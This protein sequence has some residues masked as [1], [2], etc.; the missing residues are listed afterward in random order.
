MQ[1]YILYSNYD[2]YGEEQQNICGIFITEKLLDEYF[3]ESKIHRYNFPSINYD[4]IETDYI[5]EINSIVHVVICYISD[6]EGGCYSD[7]EDIF[8]TL[9]EAN[10][11]RNKYIKENKDR[12]KDYEIEEFRIDEIS[13]IYTAKELLKLETEELKK[14]KIKRKES[15][16]K[17][18]E[19]LLERLKIIDEKLGS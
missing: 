17:E 4:V 10:S 6:R 12:N 7:I 15:L 8:L 9:E 5:L 1:L 2:F 3:F 14:R 13:A 16:Y 11:S 18:K 19:N